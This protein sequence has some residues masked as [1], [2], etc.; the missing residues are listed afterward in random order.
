M[1]HHIF[2]ASHIVQEYSCLNLVYSH[3]MCMDKTFVVTFELKTI[4]LMLSMLIC[5]FNK[6]FGS[7]NVYFMSYSRFR[8]KSRHIFQAS[9]I[10][11]EY[12]CLNPLCSRN[13]CMTKNS[14]VTFERSTTHFMLPILICTF[15][16][17]FGSQ[18]V[19]FKNIQEYSCLKLLCK[20]KACMGR[21]M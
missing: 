3:N 6:T 17:T 16:K 14:I 15:S 10:I 1:S 5:T 19:Y 18:I 2:Q 4:H 13:V 11:Q 9:H 12:A 20:N 21:I 8:N 7:L